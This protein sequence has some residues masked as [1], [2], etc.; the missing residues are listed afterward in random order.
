[1]L[2]KYYRGLNFFAMV[3]CVYVNN[4]HLWNYIYGQ[5]KYAKKLNILKVNYI[6]IVVMMVFLS[7][8]YK[9]LHLCK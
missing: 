1:M 7:G 8:K 6:I 3:Q 9:M 2:M 5:L 4:Y